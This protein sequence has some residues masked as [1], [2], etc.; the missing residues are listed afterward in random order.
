MHQTTASG[1]GGLTLVL[2]IALYF[3]PTIIAAC[4]RHHNRSAI[5]LLDLLLGWTV[6]GWIG[7]LIWSATA[8]WP[9]HNP[10]SLPY[11]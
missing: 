1:D 6:A 11:P 4:R 2:L 9:R 7:A 3:L 8:V 5:F 10:H